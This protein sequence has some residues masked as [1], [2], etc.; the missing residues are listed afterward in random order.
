MHSN[1]YPK[2]PAITNIIHLGLKGYDAFGELAADIFKL[3]QES[4]FL[5]R[6]SLFQ[7]LYREFNSLQLDDIIYPFLYISSWN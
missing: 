2:P 3:S 5:S 7:V 6:G 4:D 1:K